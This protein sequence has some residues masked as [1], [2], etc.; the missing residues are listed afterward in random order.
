MKR[1]QYNSRSFK[2]LSTQHDARDD[3]LCKT[4]ASIVRVTK[5]TR[6]KNPTLRPPTDRHSKKPNI[7]EDI[8]QRSQAYPGRRQWKF[9]DDL[10]DALIPETQDQHIRREEDYEAARSCLGLLRRRLLRSCLLRRC[11]LGCRRRLLRWL[12]SGGFGLGDTTRLGLA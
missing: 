6:D 2:R 12:S 1:S 8:T 5:G 4:I 10:E 3:Q 9:S 7:R 11:L